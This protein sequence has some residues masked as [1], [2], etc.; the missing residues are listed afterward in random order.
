MNRLSSFS[1][2]LLSVFMLALPANAHRGRG[3]AASGGGSGPAAPS[4]VQII[5][6]GKNAPSSS[7]F[8]IPSQPNHQTIGWHQTTAP[9][10][11]NVYRYQI[12]AG[13][14]T[15]SAGFPV[16]VPTATAA[17]T[18]SSYVTAQGSF[19]VQSGV[20]YAYV[21]SAA[22]NAVGSAAGPHIGL[23]SLT[24][25]SGTVTA[26]SAVPIG[27][28]SLL[29]VTISGATPSGYNGTFVATVTGT[30][31]FTYS[32]ASNPGT[33]TVPGAWVSNSDALSANGLIGT[34]TFTSGATS[35]VVASVTQG[36]VSSGDGVG[37]PCI[38]RGTTFTSG[39]LGTTG[40]Y[41]ISQPTLC[42]ESTASPMGT[43]FF[44]NTAYLYKVTAVTGGVE[45]AQSDYDIMV[46]FA[47]GLQIMNQGAFGAVP[48]F[49]ATCPITSPLGFGTCANVTLNTGTGSG[50]G[51]FTGNSGIGWN[52][53]VN[54]M[55]YLNVAIMAPTGQ[56][57]STFFFGTELAG[58][59]IVQ[60]SFNG[61]SGFSGTPLPPATW[62]TNKF[63][64]SSIYALSTGAQQDGFYKLVFTTHQTSNNWAGGTE[65]YYMEIWWSF[66]LRP[67]TFINARARLGR[68]AGHAANDPYF[69]Q[70]L[71]DAV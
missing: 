24:W 26:T 39:S 71:K 44:P 64:L 19:P 18:Y 47:N 1:L 17:T 66:N 67:Q 43:V 70:L 36:A 5:L 8:A 6:Q 3:A 12:V 61:S 28:V 45:S 52:I 15:L 29:F 46:F 49:G 42:A 35:I 22:T 63:A 50:S 23:S 11:F 9:T 53:G 7:D 14:P 34:A 69:S 27:A 41:T 58:D 68:H 51:M 40:T 38:A 16:S 10:S 54:G 60:M 62:V 25:S 32:V 33:E 37:G 30:S 13:T 55:N 2:L 31:T 59:A 65:N 21:D 4:F 20:N 56:T 48:S 57:G